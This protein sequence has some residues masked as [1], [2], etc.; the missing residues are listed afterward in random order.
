MMSFGRGHAG[1]LLKLVDSASEASHLSGAILTASAWMP[2]A[3]RSNSE[4]RAS[5]SSSSIALLAKLMTDSEHRARVEGGVA[6][7]IISFSSVV[8]VAEKPG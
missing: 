8:A 6:G 1:A 3:W 7:S 4:T 2:P 5:M